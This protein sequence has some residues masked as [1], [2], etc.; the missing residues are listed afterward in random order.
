MYYRYI[1]R[2]K[3]ATREQVA[4]VV[5]TPSSKDSG[6]WVL[7]LEERPNDPVIPFVD[8]FLCLIEDKFDLLE[9]I[10]VSR[11][12]ITIWLLYE[13][14]EQCNMEFS[15]A[16]LKRLGEAGIALCVSCWQA[17]SNANDGQAPGSDLMRR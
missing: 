4:Q 9:G 15:A 2:I 16:D 7:E 17:A 6:S 13:Y 3:G 1:L 14:D 10:G 11:D 5:Q 8:L 12:D